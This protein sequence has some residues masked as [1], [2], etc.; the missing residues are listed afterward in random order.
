[1]IFFPV[2]ATIQ[3]R[4]SLHSFSRVAP[5]HPR[6]ASEISLRS[7]AF[8]GY[9]LSFDIVPNSFALTKNSTRLFSSK[10]ELFSKNT[11]GWGATLQTRESL[12]LRA[13]PLIRALTFHALTNCKSRNSF[14]LIFMQIGGGCTPSDVV[15]NARSGRSAYNFNCT[16]GDSEPGCGIPGSGHR[17]SSMRR[18]R[19]QVNQRARTKA[20]GTTMRK[21][22]PAVSCE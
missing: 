19:T 10:S 3:P 13:A 4:R 9:L 11:G 18:D 5:Y 12:P 16:Y 17:R 8:P 6:H 14:P 21:A 7:P 20:A 2:F 15:F 1:M 22:I